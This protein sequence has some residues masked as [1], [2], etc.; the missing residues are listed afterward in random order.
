MK[1]RGGICGVGLSTRALQSS[2]PIRG[3]LLDQPLVQRPQFEAL[4]DI[5]GL[6]RL[7]NRRQRPLAGEPAAPFLGLM[8]A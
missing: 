8:C 2:V 3:R 1:H 6:L 4:R 5:A 7:Q